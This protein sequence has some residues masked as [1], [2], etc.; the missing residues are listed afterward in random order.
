MHSGMVTK[1]HSTDAYTDS[2]IFFFTAGLNNS[3]YSEAS[4]LQ[5]YCIYPKYSDN[6]TPN[7]TYCKIKQVYLLMSE[8]VS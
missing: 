5:E 1:I 2:G 4:T 7:H 6:L 3:D 8:T